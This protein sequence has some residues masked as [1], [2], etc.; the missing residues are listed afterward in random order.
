M[1]RRTSWILLTLF[2]L[3]L[4]VR[5]LGLG[6][7][8]Y[9]TDATA[10]LLSFFILKH[11][12]FFNNLIARITSVFFL[13]L[14]LSLLQHRI[15]DLFLQIHGVK[16]ITVNTIFLLTW[17]IFS[18]IIFREI[19][20]NSITLTFWMMISFILGSSVY[21]NPREFH[22]FYRHRTYEEYIRSIYTEKNESLADYY[23][24]KY[25]T[26]DKIKAGL[27]L[28]EA[29]KAENNGK[30]DEAL[31]SYNKSIDNDPDDPVAYHRRGFLKLTKLD[32]NED[33]A[34]SA[35]KD[36]DRVIK[37]DSTYTI[38]YFHRGMTIGYLGDKHQAA[39][40]FKK[41]WYADSSLSEDDF[42]NKYGMSKKSF[43]VPLHP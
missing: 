32:I 19:I 23:I 2:I 15:P 26:T 38:A 37:L 24:D 25:K 27:Y 21:L 10:I 36:F 34:H 11:N 20:D 12:V 30:Y 33:I 43:P 35:L 40:D 8:S 41:V 13:I 3:T 42:R 39:E 5:K 9:L 4:L 29:F 7:S 6:Y 17:M 28:D 14:C 31:E 18:F 16:E 1:D 22:N